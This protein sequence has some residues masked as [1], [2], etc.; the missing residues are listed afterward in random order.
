MQTYLTALYAIL[1]VGFFAWLLS[2][3]KRNVSFVDSLWSL[4]FLIATGVFAFSAHPLGARG[5]L[6]V[7]LVTCWALRL[8]IYI[9]ARNWGEA[10]DYRYQAIRTKNEPGFAFKSLY[11]VFGLQGLLA[12]LI[13]LPLLPAVTEATGLGL[14][15]AIAI[16]LWTVGFIFEAGGDYQLLQFRKN[17]DNRGQVLNTGLWRLTRHPNYFGDFCVWWAY[18]LFALSAGGWW[19]LASPILM[20][21]L[22]LRISG[23]VMLE[24]TITQRRP[25]YAEYIR[26]TNA[27]FPG[28]KRNARDANEAK[29]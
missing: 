11:I 29:S 17:P 7:T 15:D 21:F 6:V 5:L 22:L 10:E 14:F 12:W 13:A 20:S 26:R 23:V 16:L 8:S 18:Y 1:A 2:V 19:S 24:K 25:E 3:V 9:T 28:P 4:F 27:F